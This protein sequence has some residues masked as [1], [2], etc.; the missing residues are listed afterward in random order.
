MQGHHAGYAGMLKYL[1]NEFRSLASTSGGNGRFLIYANVI[2]RIATDLM[3]SD[4]EQIET[5]ESVGGSHAA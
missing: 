5:V 2:E 4:K 3:A 1:S